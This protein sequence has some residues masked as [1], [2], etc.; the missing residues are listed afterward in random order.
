MSMIEI[1]QRQ[2]SVRY[3][4]ILPVGVKN[5]EAL[6]IPYKNAPNT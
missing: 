2:T 3:L 6:N 5:I 1:K 4:T